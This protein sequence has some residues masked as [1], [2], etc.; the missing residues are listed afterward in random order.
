MPTTGRGDRRQRVVF[1]GTPA[2]AVPTL[3]A[4]A[5][6]HQVLGVAT[7][8]DR[9]R[10]RGRKPQVSPVKAWALEHAIS[11]VQPST[12]RDAVTRQALEALV[13]DVLVVVAYGLLLP[14]E[15]LA[16]PARGCV[17]LHTSLLPRHRGASPIQAA[18]LAG[19]QMT[20]VTTM[21]MDEGLDTGPVLEQVQIPVNSDDTAASLG[22]RLADVG[23]DLMLSTLDGLAAGTLQPRAQD[24][25]AATMTRLIRKQ[26]GRIDWQ[27]EGSQIDRQVRAMQPWPSAWTQWRGTRVQVWSV[28]PV[29]GLPPAVRGR[30]ERAD[31]EL[32]IGCGDG[33]VRIDCLQRAGGKS[34]TAVEFLRGARLQPGERFGEAEGL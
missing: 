25:A 3:A 6:R 18:I 9:P 7:Q 5:A 27:Q 31:S 33:T 26:H 16:I 22:D 8:P 21:L 12:W 24:P 11:V 30:V 28:E 32:H 23:A 19:D 13:P 29:S 10:G 4:V 15:V 2:L 20:G 34:M 14:A 17:N 1:L